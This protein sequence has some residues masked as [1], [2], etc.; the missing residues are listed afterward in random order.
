MDT[1][2][3]NHQQLYMS[4]VRQGLDGTSSHPYFLCSTPERIVALGH[5]VASQGD[6]LGQAVAAGVASGGF[7][8]GGVVGDGVVA[9]G[10]GADAV[11]AGGV[12][13]VGV[14]T[15]GR[16]ARTRRGG[17][18]RSQQSS[19][20]QA[21]GPTAGGIARGGVKNYT[22]AEVDSLLQ[23]IKRVCPIGND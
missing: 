8:A 9:G 19:G 22:P 18:R 4:P 2:L 5:R 12:M 6:G 20:R 21:A 14:V 1:P 23:T 16:G 13:T 17:G 7:V 3:P 11:V 15:G 10:A